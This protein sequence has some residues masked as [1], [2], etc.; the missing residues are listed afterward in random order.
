MREEEEGLYAT[1]LFSHRK[2]H[3]KK[4]GKGKRRPSAPSRSSYG[5]YAEPRPPTSHDHPEPEGQTIVSGT[6]QLFH[7]LAGN[8]SDSDE[9]IAA[10][11]KK[12]EESRLP[13]DAVDL[14]VEDVQAEEEEMVRDRR[15]GDPGTKRKKVFRQL[16]S[17]PSPILQPTTEVPEGL[18][19]E[20]KDTVPQEVLS[21]DEEGT[22]EEEVVR[23]TAQ[24]EEEYSRQLSRPPSPEAKRRED[25]P[26]S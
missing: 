7:A 23:V 12:E 3:K 18:N 5:Q 2:L 26:W 17:T 16:V 9:E 21:R 10:A 25:N 15:R 8:H 19:I 24:E 6:R 20:V 1:P 14:V 4:H 22:R 13:A 11:R